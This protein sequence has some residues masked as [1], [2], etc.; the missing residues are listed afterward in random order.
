MT[1]AT[2]RA[3][4]IE[5]ARRARLRAVLDFARAAR[6]WGD[7]LDG[8]DN[9][10]RAH[11]RFFAE[12]WMRHVAASAAAAANPDLRS[13]SSLDD[14]EA[15]A[16]ALAA[17]MSGRPIEAAAAAAGEREWLNTALH[18]A[19]RAR[20]AADEMVRRNVDGTHYLHRLADEW[21][22]KARAM[23]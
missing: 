7:G 20:D 5:A 21:E 3:A 18:A 2:L 1:E 16:A 13:P 14:L 4:M 19:A 10:D 23:G 12:A 22:A 9:R 8:V 6:D 17:R 15:R 11:T